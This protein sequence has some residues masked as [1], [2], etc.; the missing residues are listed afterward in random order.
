MTN[1]IPAASAI[2]MDDQ[3]RVLLV[4]RGTEP[5]KGRWSVP[6]GTCEPGESFADTA[7]RE[8]LEETGLHVTID[9]ELWVVTVPAGDGRKFEI[10]DFAATATGGH[11]KPGDDAVDARWVADSD[12]DGLPLTKDLAAYLRGAGIFNT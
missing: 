4:L 2:I 3:R 8:A 1:I 9:R 12:L 6:G 10:H 11:L 7:A 5:E